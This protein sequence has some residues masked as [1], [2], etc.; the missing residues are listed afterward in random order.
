M[1]IRFA[2]VSSDLLAKVR[3]EVDVLLRAV[4]TGD[5]ARVDSTTENL[6]KLTSDCRSIDLSE[7]EWRTFL[8]E[9][10]A[11]NPDLKSNYLLP[12]DIFTAL[13]STIEDDDYVLELPIDGDMEE[14]NVDV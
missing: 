6:L 8:N 10:R 3:A 11:K 13:F 12:G 5:M 2:I 7:D 1:K 4:N 14:E 9:L